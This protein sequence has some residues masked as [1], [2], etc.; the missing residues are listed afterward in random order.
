[1]NAII[2]FEPEERLRIVGRRIGYPPTSP[3]RRRLVEWQVLAFLIAGCNVNPHCNRVISSLHRI[4]ALQENQDING[5]GYAS[6]KSNIT[7]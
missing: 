7:C 4:Q 5:Y 6:I 3:V 1:M 2:A